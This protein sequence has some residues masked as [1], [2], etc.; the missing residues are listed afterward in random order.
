M[1][2]GDPR[3]EAVMGLTAFPN[4]DGTVEVIRGGEPVTLDREGV[5][6][7]A[8]FSLSERRFLLGLLGDCGCG[9][10]CAAGP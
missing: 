6:G 1:A 2:A 5:E 7:S 8:S 10:A 4:G 9:G 3:E